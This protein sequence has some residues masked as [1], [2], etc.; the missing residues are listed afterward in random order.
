MAAVV[1]SSFILQEIIAA[2]YNADALQHAG[3]QSFR[4]IFRG[5]HTA[6]L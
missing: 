4:A 5:M 1:N 6:G 2:Y 3:L